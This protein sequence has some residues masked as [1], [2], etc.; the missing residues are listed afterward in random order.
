MTDFLIT[1]SVDGTQAIRMMEEI[2]QRA[3]ALEARLNALGRGTGGGATNILNNI[4]LGP[5]NIRAATSALSGLERQ[6]ANLSAARTARTQLGLP[7]S[8]SALATEAVATRRLAEALGQTSPRYQQLLQDSQNLAAQSRDLSSRLDETNQ[9]FAR[10]TR[11]IF[12]AILIYEAFGRA[13]QAIQ[14]GV[15]LVID[16]D[17][18]T[19]RLEAVLEID[20][21][22]SAQFIQNLGQIASDTV[23]PIG[24]LVTEADRMAAAFSDIEDPIKREAAALELANRAGQLTTVTQ[25]N[26]GVETQNVIAIMK[27]LGIPIDDLGDFLGKVVVAGGNASTRI[28]EI[29]DALQVS[30]TAASESG[31]NIDILLGILNRFIVVSGRTGSEA[32][33]IFKQLFTKLADPDVIKGVNEITGGVLRLRDSVGNLRDPFEVLLELNALLDQGVIS[34]TQWSDVVDTIAPPLSPQT[35]VDFKNVLKNLDQI[36]AEV[37]EIGAADVSSLDD[38]VNKI[39]DALGPQFQKLIIDAQNAFNQLF[40]PGILSTGQAFIDVIRGI[41]TALAALPPEVLTTVATLATILAAV[42]ALKFAVGGLAAVLGLR[43][44]GLAGTFISLGSASTVAATG[45]AAVGTASTAATAGIAGAAAAAART[46]V[47]FTGVAAGSTAATAGMTGVAGAAT[48]AS[49]ATTAAG[50]AAAR[51]GTAFTLLGTT[52]FTAGG[53]VAGLVKQ[54]AILL[55]LL[56]AFMAF[57]FAGKVGEMQQGLRS[58]LGQQF[59][60][61]DLEGLKAERARIA[62]ELQKQAQFTANPFELVGRTLVSGTLV[63]SLNEVTALI[64]EL[65]KRG[66]AG[67][68]GLDDLSEGFRGVDDAASQ[69]DEI[70]A[71]TQSILDQLMGSTSGYA[72][73]LREV[74]EA[75]R[76]AA[77]SGTLLKGLNDE[78]ASSLEKLSDRLRDGKI[79]AD[80]FATGQDNVSRAAELS[81]Q[82]VAAASDELAKVPALADA[83]AQGNDELAAA[84]FNMIVQSTDQLPAIDQIISKIVGL[85]GATVGAAQI[86]AANPIIVRTFI[87]APVNGGQIP[88]GF[89]EGTDIFGAPSGAVTRTLPA[90]VV[91]FNVAPIA[92]QIARQ[93]NALIG[94]LMN[95][96]SGG[97]SREF[98]VGPSP[99]TGTSGGTTRTRQQA[100]TFDIGDLPRDQIVK[101]IAIATRLRNQI[102]GERQASKDELVALIKNAKFLQTVKGIDD[103]LLRIALDR[104]TDQMT[105]ANEREEAKAQRDNILRNLTVNAGPLGALVSQPTAFG[106]GGSL[107]AGNGLNFDPTKGNFVINVPVT[108][109]GL[110]PAQ[111][112]QLIYNIIGKAIRDALRL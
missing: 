32:G 50:V 94:G 38:L 62:A 69:S 95:T 76:I 90:G 11:R 52:L 81:A 88:G 28:A 66:T 103:R 12:E 91:P 42:S 85:A 80:E 6:V 13:I 17:R 89:H 104:L 23:T 84:I 93:I 79:S 24:D 108:L 33:N 4:G 99:S 100:T 58:Q 3:T 25:R 27:Q 29:T 110:N 18:E 14:A 54:F 19:R 56:A 82:V 67:K 75:D 39:N 92:E 57:D 73:S 37:R 9:S 101:L 106:V 35:A 97:T 96:V 40:G 70:L 41:G 47:A 98:G 51:S 65:E 83:A 43:G 109:K 72:Q 21:T 102:P 86:V 46:G 60:G 36:T 87:A 68:V 15:D 53:L 55:P 1:F 34:A 71:D 26:L 49:T 45:M 22:Q 5:N 77:E 7:Q 8:A 74:S 10:H 2:G 48:A 16:I 59:V 30:A 107:A 61:L 44:L 31:A 112:Q 105:K 78:I 63:E 20:P 64:E 111:L